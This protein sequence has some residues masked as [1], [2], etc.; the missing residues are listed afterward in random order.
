MIT[1]SK[2]NKN[3][4]SEIANVTHAAFGQ[5]TEAAIIESLRRDG[6]LTVSLVAEEGGKI[7]GHIAFSPVTL[8]MVD[9]KIEALGLGP[10]AVLPEHQRRQIGTQLIY[11]GLKA[12]RKINAGLV[13]VLGH[14]EYYP[15]F[16]FVPTFPYNIAWEVECPKEAFM[17]LELKEAALEGLSGVVKYHPAFMAP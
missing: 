1:I 12:C 11:E 5:K 10:M 14:P 16:G 13:F 4:I 8:E 9:Q 17:V 3:N 7:V 2:E 6:A 15:R